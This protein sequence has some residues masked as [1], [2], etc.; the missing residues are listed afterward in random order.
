MYE[1]CFSARQ[2][3]GGASR[4]PSGQA[5]LAG[6]STTWRVGRLARTRT[7][8]H[9]AAAAWPLA[10]H[11]TGGRRVGGTR[12]GVGAPRQA[13]LL[14]AAN[15]HRD[16]A[17]LTARGRAVS[18]A[19]HCNR[20][21]AQPLCSCRERARDLD[22]GPPSLLRSHE[23]APQPLRCW[24][25]ARTRNSVVT[26]ALSNRLAGGALK[27]SRRRAG[28]RAGGRGCPPAFAAQ[29]AAHARRL[30]N[31]RKRVA[32][33]PGSHMAACGCFGEAT[34]PLFTPRDIPWN[35]RRP[36]LFGGSEA[37]NAGFGRVPPRRY[38]TAAGALLAAYGHRLSSP[39][40]GGAESCGR[41]APAC[42]RPEGEETCLTPPAGRCP[43]PPRA[44]TPQPRSRHGGPR[45]AAAA[46]LPAA[47]RGGA[48]A[49]C[50]AVKPEPFQNT[51]TP[52]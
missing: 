29:A 49:G 19:Q 7:L 32:H 51:D 10:A 40:G 30:P 18:G 44:E 41:R 22:A 50:L 6:K 38:P 36:R 33:L 48:A 45:A 31:R 16:R 24:R 37:D 34:T 26:C 1:T 47:G 23:L 4:R 35:R 39:L 21:L 12:R 28:S 43:A 2:S 13:A 15:R 3:C 8:R 14:W 27:Q 17:A 46:R 52:S 20:P 9:Q 11:P 5:L 25:G 42:R